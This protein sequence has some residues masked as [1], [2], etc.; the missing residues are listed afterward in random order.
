MKF[1]FYDFESPQYSQYFGET[2]SFYDYESPQ[3][4]RIFYKIAVFCT[5]LSQLLRILKRSILLGF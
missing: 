4:A 1:I 2:P 5:K 3:Y